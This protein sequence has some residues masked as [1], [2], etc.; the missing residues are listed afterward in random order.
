[1]TTLLSQ[2]S[3]GLL[4]LCYIKIM[5]ATIVTL[6]SHSALQILKGAKEEGF[7]TLILTAWVGTF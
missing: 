1:M 2:Y 3:L 7:R 4:P 5:K 6:G